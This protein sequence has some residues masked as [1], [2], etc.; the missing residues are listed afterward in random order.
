M[1]E[2][3]PGN[4]PGGEFKGLF[5]LEWS[6]LTLS[7]KFDDACDIFLIKERESAMN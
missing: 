1:D 3:S 7:C 5:T 2:R 6:N 4:P